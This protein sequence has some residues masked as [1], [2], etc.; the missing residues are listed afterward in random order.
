MYH[1]RSRTSGKYLDQPACGDHAQACGRWRGVN[2]RYAIGMLPTSNEGHAVSI[3]RSKRAGDNRLILIDSNIGYPKLLSDEA[4]ENPHRWEIVVDDGLTQQP[5][6]YVII[7]ENQQ[8][9]IPETPD[10]IS[11]DLD[12][13]D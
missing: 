8:A 13:D 10:V 1:Y 7:Y 11:L 12:S 2:F 4:T 5:Q 9:S 6:P 3:V